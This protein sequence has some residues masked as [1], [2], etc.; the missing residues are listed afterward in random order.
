MV[1]PTT[2][3]SNGMKL[4]MRSNR[5]GPGI[6]AASKGISDPNKAACNMSSTASSR[7]AELLGSDEFKSARMLH[8][9]VPAVTGM[10]RSIT[11]KP[12][13][14]TPALKNPHD[15]RKPLPVPIATAALLTLAVAAKTVYAVSGLPSRSYRTPPR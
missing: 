5:S 9:P 1:C 4:V 13:R 12:P 7:A 14:L 2:A 15:A 11:G 3:S 6:A 8:D 10:V